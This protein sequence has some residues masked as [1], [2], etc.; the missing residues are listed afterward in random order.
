MD[1][2]SNI[3]IKYLNDSKYGGWNNNPHIGYITPIYEGSKNKCQYMVPMDSM[4]Q[5]NNPHIALEPINIYIYIYIHTYI[6]YIYTVTSIQPDLKDPCPPL[7]LRA[8]RQREASAGSRW[9]QRGARARGHHGGHGPGAHRSQD[10]LQSTSKIWLGFP[11][12]LP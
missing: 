10:L 8:C 11:L 6:C 12:N 1:Y 3:W 9:P 7:R 5:Y 4:I 2:T